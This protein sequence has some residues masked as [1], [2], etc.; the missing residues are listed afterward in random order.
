MADKLRQI[1]RF[2]EL[3]GHQFDEGPLKDAKEVHVADL[4]AGKGYLT[5]ATHDFLR[6]RGITGT[7][8]DGTRD[9]QERVDVG[10][11][12]I[13]ADGTDLAGALDQVVDG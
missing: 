2:V 10:A 3:L 5:F 11:G 7:V 12:E 4:G 13:G 9:E 1:E 6:K 8:G